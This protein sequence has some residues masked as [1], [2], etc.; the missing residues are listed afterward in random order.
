M[1]CLRARNRWNILL[2]WNL[3]PYGQGCGGENVRAMD[4]Y[5]LWAKCGLPFM[6]VV[7]ML[8]I[9]LDRSNHPAV[10]GSGA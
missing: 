3:M 9:D 2:L 1:D 8:P 10:R 4:I 6:A 5:A 7:I